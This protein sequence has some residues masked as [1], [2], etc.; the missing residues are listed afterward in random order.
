MTRSCKG[1]KVG[2]TL[3][4]VSIAVPAAA[5]GFHD[6]HTLKEWAEAYDRSLI[7][8]KQKPTDTRDV[9]T[10]MGYVTGVNDALQGMILCTPPGVK[11]HELVWSSRN[12]S[13][14]TPKC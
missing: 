11:I 6:G 5:A 7:G 4:A 1:W 12:T 2:L 9:L 13:G 3:L 14:S 8:E 10:F